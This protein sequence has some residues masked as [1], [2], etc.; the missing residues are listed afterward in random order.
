MYPLIVLTVYNQNVCEECGEF[1][2]D[3]TEI[4]TKIVHW[5][6]AAIECD[7]CGCMIESAYGDPFEEE[8]E[9]DNA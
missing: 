7:R 8:D 1:A 2:F 4:F 3:S 5:E 9:D 6:G